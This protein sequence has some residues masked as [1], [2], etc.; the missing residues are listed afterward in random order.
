MQKISE[1]L[2]HHLAKIAEE[3]EGEGLIEASSSIDKSL[4]ILSGGTPHVLKHPVAELVLSRISE[5]TDIEEDLKIENVKKES[6]E[7]LK[8]I[9]NSLAN[10]VKQISIE[11]DKEKTIG[12]FAT[13]QIFSLIVNAIEDFTD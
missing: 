6:I 7:Y 10:I 1:D 12:L 13:L 3:L 8:S 4:F 2:L 11:E 9:T 5:L